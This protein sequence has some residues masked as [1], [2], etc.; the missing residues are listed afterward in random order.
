[1][2]VIRQH[3]STHLG[4]LYSVL[5]P[6]GTWRLGQILAELC[7][8]EPVAVRATKHQAMPCRDFIRSNRKA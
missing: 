3:I 1:M 7:P 5:L 4:R 2:N 8:A 6:G